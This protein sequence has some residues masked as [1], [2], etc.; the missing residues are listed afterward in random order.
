VLNLIPHQQNWI[1]GFSGILQPLFEQQ[2]KTGMP[3]YLIIF[4]FLCGLPFL[5]R[6]G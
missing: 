6:R 4:A 2:E 5:K 3:S 1:S